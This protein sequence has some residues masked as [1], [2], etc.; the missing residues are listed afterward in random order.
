MDSIGSAIGAAKLFN[1]IA[2]R[3]SEV[4][5]ETKWALKN[6][7]LTLPPRYLEV[8]QK[9]KVCLM[10]HNQTGQMEP[11][12]RACNVSGIIDH[13]ALQSKTIQTDAPIFID[14]RPWGSACT[15]IGH[16]YL[17]LD[18]PFEVPVAGILLSG[19]LSDTLN[20]TSPTTTQNDRELVA[21]LAKAA[22]VKDINALAQSQFKAKSAE[23]DKMTGLQVCLAPHI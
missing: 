12:I 4:N 10:D 13:H 19:I 18:A 6:W 11:N 23:L 20:L 22:N 7:G 21:V 5:S 9:A 2:A 14:I 1:G 3:A 16:M 8:D 17:K 15:I